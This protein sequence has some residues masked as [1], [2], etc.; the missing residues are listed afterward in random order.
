MSSYPGAR[1]QNWKVTGFRPFAIWAGR[2][3][4][5]EYCSAEQRP[6]STCSSRWIEAFRSSNPS[7]GLQIGV[8]L[9]RAR[10]NSFQELAPHRAAIASAASGVLRGSVT[11]LDLRPPGR[12]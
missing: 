11:E 4:E 12:E 7:G 3:S 1:S 5:T 8:L 2:G 6:T 9:I 10:D